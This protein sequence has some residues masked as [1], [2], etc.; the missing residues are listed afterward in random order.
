MI[1][2]VGAKTFSDGL[3]MG[4]EVYHF[5]RQIL[6]K[7][8][9]AQQ[10]GMKADLRRI[11]PTQ[12]E[13]FSYLSK[14]VKLAE[15]IMW[16]R[17]L[18]MPWMRR[19][20]S[21]M[22]RRGVYVFPGED[23][24]ERD[25]EEMIALYEELITEFPI[26]S[27]ED[28]LS[29]DDWDGWQKMTVRLGDKIQLVGDDLFV[30]NPKRIKCGID[31]KAANA[32]LIKLNQIGTVTEAMDAIGDG[33]MC[34]NE[35]DHLTPPGGDRGCFFWQTLRSQS[36]QDRSRQELRRVLSVR[37]KYNQLLRIEEELAE[38]ARFN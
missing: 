6:D 35:Y 36:M 20:V 10:S 3:K 29:E 18:Y 19:Q 27:I 17:I 30:T 26:I 23:G 15:D 22:M 21:C 34:R 7:E 33:K 28:G 12:K 5:L 2:P 16:V 13:V 11:L 25:T 37:Q 4:A 24:C 8:G 31:L 32:V 9:K 14:A 1:V 38:Q